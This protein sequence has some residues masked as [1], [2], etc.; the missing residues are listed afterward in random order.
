M[1]WAALDPARDEAERREIIDRFYAAYEADVAADPRGT[2]WPTCTASC[3]CAK[4]VR[5][6]AARKI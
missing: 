6:R 5:E 2:P 3:G 1:F 4:R